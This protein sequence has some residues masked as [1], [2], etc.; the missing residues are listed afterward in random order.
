MAAELKN[1]S[2]HARKAVGD[3]MATL[4]QTEE[5][6]DS[7]QDAMDVNNRKLKEQTIAMRRSTCWVWLMLLAVCVIFVLM[8]ILMKI[9]PKRKP[10]TL[11]R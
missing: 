7:N 2:L 11:H 5:T 3:D 4:E 6:L 9:F 8:F 10:P 1:K